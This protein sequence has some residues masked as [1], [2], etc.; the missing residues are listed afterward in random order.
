MDETIASARQ[1]AGTLGYEWFLAEDGS[2]CEINERFA[3]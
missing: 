1:E 2:T 3:D